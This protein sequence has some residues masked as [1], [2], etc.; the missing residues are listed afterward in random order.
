MTLAAASSSSRCLPFTRCRP[1]KS[2]S[3]SNRFTIYIKPAQQSSCRSGSAPAKIA[4]YGQFFHAAAQQRLSFSM[5]IIGFPL[6]DFV[7]NTIDSA[8]IATPHGSF[9]SIT[10][11]SSTTSILIHSL[12]L[13]FRQPSSRITHLNKN[14]LASRVS[15][16]HQPCSGPKGHHSIRI[17][18]RPIFTHD[19]TMLSLKCPSRFST[20]KLVANTPAKETTS[21]RSATR[22]H[23]LRA[24]GH[25]GRIAINDRSTVVNTPSS[26]ALKSGAQRTNTDSKPRLSFSAIRS[27]GSSNSIARQTILP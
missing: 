23:P 13:Q 20:S 19:I 18:S 27:P 9:M 22:F 10:S 14:G 4:V 1:N 2:K 3:L 17:H 12:L 24:T 15:K 7:A 11:I 26:K 5:S 21:D 8:Y 6:S 25:Q 16:Q